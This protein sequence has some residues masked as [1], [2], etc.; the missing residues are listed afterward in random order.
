MDR[1]QDAPVNLQSRMTAEESIL[2]DAEYG[3]TYGSNLLNRIREQGIDI[4]GKDVLELGPGTAFGAMAYY[5][6]HGARVAVADRWL[7]PWQ[8]DYHASYYAALADLI[9]KE[10]KGLDTGPVRR[11]VEAGGY[12]G[13]VIRCLKEPAEA[14]TSCGEESIDV[15]LSNAVMEHVD[16]LDAV[17]AELFRI[18]RRGGIG[19]HQID[20]RHHSDGGPLEHLLISTTE[21]REISRA[22]HNEQGSQLRQVDYAAAI[23]KAGFI[24]RLYSSSVSAPDSYLDD[25]IPRLRQL[26]GSPWRNSPRNVL[27]DLG[28]FFVVEKV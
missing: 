20:F 23:G 3:R 1:L 7:A 8:A 26:E 2:R 28:G 4:R 10:D 9:E 24:I 6:A 17:F 27:A 15:V 25:F 16:D 18:T 13:G 14:L 21:F 22:V 12:E 11:L 5:A 19:I